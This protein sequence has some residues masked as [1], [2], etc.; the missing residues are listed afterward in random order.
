MEDER[1]IAL[2]NARNEAAIAE[3]DAKYGA[4][5]RR[6]SENITHDPRDAEEC[7]NDTYLAAWNAIPPAHPHPLSTFLFR[8]TRNLSLKCYRRKT[9]EKRDNRSD[10]P[11]EELSDCLGETDYLPDDPERLT[12]IIEAFLDGL[13]P[14]NRV[15]FLRRYWFSDSYAAIS[16]RVGLSEKVISMRLLRMRERLR[17]HL[18]KEGIFV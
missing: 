5:C 10:I 2:Y 6:I 12:R 1:I 13:T 11:L 7:V 16:E 3:T 8:I 18:G 14:E 17:T 15:I 9:A 4:S